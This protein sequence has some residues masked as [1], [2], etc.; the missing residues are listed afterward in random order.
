MTKFSSLLKIIFILH[1]KRAISPSDFSLKHSIR[2]QNKKYCFLTFWE[3][4]EWDL[5]AAVCRYP[6]YSDNLFLSC[7]LILK[8]L[9]NFR[10]FAE[11]LK[12]M[13]PSQHFTHLMDFACLKLCSCNSISGSPTH[14]PNTKLQKNLNTQELLSGNLLSKTAQKIPMNNE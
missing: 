14:S 5:S 13:C 1:K 2:K 8:V 7:S 11:N 4:V 9:L 12:Q 10:K 3:P 6:R